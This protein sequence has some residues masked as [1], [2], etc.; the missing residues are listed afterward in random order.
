MFGLIKIPT[1]SGSSEDDEVTNE[2]AGDQHAGVGFSVVAVVV[3]GDARAC[4][5]LKYKNDLCSWFI[6]R[7][8]FCKMFTISLE[9]ITFSRSVQ[10]TKVQTQTFGF[11]WNR[12][13]YVC[14]IPNCFIKNKSTFWRE[15]KAYIT[16]ITW[17]RVFKEL[18]RKGVRE[19]NC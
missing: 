4:Q 12:M 6:L 14:T 5:R 10:T 8:L 1:C 18:V 19:T 11:W 9:R 15:Y 13:F 17:I 7:Y 16:L 2:G 3:Q